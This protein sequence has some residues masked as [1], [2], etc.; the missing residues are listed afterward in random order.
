MEVPHMIRPAIFAAVWC[1]FWAGRLYAHEAPMGWR[2][3]APCCS[4]HN[5]ANG[6]GDCHPIPASAVVPIA[7]GYRVTLRPG[8]HPTVTTVHTWD[9]T[10][11]ELM[12]PGQKLTK[13]QY[14]QDMD[15]HACLYPSES[16]L[17]CLYVT[18]GG[19]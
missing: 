9:V 1:T 5:H 14:S 12:A 3:D 10:Y 2:Y 11:E 19:V 6:R 16:V 15:F 4:Q 18:V 8:D 13:I 7:G 17:R